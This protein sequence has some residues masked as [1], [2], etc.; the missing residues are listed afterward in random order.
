[1]VEHSQVIH[2][3]IRKA[4]IE[5]NQNKI[6][7]ALLIGII[8]V[9]GF[10]YFLVSKW[11]DNQ[12]L[13]NK[14]KEKEYYC[15]MIIDWQSFASKGFVEENLGEYKI[16]NSYQFIIEGDKIKNTEA[17]DKYYFSSQ[18]G[19]PK[20]NQEVD[21]FIEELDEVNLVKTYTS[22][23]FQPVNFDFYKKEENALLKYKNKLEEL[24]YTCIEK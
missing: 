8:V 16:V 1:M 3:I 13:E 4:V 9:I 2:V 14:D 11:K 23:T 10:D 20:L 17:K 19:F 22:K 21:G 12:G 7:F 24:G 15:E 6:I 5:M 18:F